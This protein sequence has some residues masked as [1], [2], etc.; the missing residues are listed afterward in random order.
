[1][2][3]VHGA[4]TII[5]IDVGSQDNNDMTNYGDHI[6]GW[7]LLWNRI[8]PF[9]KKVRVCNSMHGLGQ[10]QSGCIVYGQSMTS[11]CDFDT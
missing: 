1:V 3:S 10:E 9:A 11:S 2:I 5:A 7:S 8:N 6:S 4:E